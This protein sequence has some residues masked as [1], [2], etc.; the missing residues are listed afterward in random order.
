MTGTVVPCEDGDRSPRTGE[1]GTMAWTVTS[2]RGSLV[3]VLCAAGCGY[4][5]ALSR[6]VAHAPRPPVCPRCRGKHKQTRIKRTKRRYQ[7]LPLQ[8]DGTRR[9]PATPLQPGDTIGI[10]CLLSRA[11]NNGK[12]PVWVAR[13]ECGVVRV[14][15]A[16][17]LRRATRCQCCRSQRKETP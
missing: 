8:H 6:V 1:G 3:D 2:E 14:V 10:F 17:N 13:C 15:Q 12:H 5:T 4:R 11:D 9:R 7:T 16:N